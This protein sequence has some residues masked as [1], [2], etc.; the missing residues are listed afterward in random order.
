LGIFHRLR[1]D[2]HKVLVYSQF[3]TMLDIIQDYL[4]MTETRFLR[5]D[6]T[7]SLAR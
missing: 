7:T 4:M 2:G 6:G 1:K 3:T 5:L